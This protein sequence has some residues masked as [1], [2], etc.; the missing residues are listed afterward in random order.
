LNADREYLHLL[1]TVLL[2]Y[3]AKYGL[4]TA[5]RELFHK[6]PS[7]RGSDEQAGANESGSGQEPP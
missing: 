4:T 5:A 6:D 7:L 2:D 3:V 1:E